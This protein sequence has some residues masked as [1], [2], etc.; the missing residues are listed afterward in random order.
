MNLIFFFYEVLI[1]PVITGCFCGVEFLLYKFY[2]INVLL[3][4][5]VSNVNN[6]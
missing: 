6:L 1:F 5:I 4:N 2:V 3:E